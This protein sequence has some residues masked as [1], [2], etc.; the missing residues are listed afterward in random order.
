MS[1]KRMKHILFILRK[2]QKLP[3]SLACMLLPFDPTYLLTNVRVCVCVCVHLC[4]TDK[5]D[6]PQE[7]VL[8][9]LRRRNHWRGREKG[10]EFS[11]HRPG[12]QSALKY[13]HC[14]PQLYAPRV[15]KRSLKLQNRPL[16]DH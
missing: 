9:L 13:L 16:F 4:R 12:I 14:Q 6:F 1:L 5:Q 15:A 3:T 8:C 2:A 11:L 7:R 10:C